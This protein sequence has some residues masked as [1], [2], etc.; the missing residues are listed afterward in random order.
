M[1]W[2]KMCVDDSYRL[3]LKD[4]DGWWSAIVKWDGCIHFYRYH[5][6]P[7]KDHGENVGDMV[8]YLH[9]C[10]IDELINGLQELKAR[11]IGKF[12]NDWGM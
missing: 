8:D 3:E 11:A 7:M 6:E 4:R 2:E 12:G 10:D 1:N 5:N 9:I